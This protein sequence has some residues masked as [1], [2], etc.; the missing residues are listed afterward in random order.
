MNIRGQERIHH[1]FDLNTQLRW[2]TANIISGKCSLTWPLLTNMG[3]P[4]V[5][6]TAPPPHFTI[7]R[8]SMM[9]TLRTT[10]W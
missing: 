5:A 1:Q 2:R 4:P 7:Q 9:D 10:Y 3:T 6:A 8:G